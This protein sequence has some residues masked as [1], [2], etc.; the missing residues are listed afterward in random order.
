MRR[1]LLRGLPARGR[2]CM[3]VRDARKAGFHWQSWEEVEHIRWEWES[4]SPSAS[5]GLGVFR[6]LTELANE[7]RS[8]TNVSVGGSDRFRTEQKEIAARAMVS[9]RTAA[10]A[11]E[12]LE[13]IGMLAI[14]AD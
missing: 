10:R 2:G 9:D 8:R 6:A 11:C 12:E 13:R 7:D 14:E 5:A 4:S 3:S 1:R